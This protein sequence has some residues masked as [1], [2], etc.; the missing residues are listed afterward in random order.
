MGIFKNSLAF[1]LL[2]IS[3][4][5]LGLPLLVDSFILLHRAYV[6][7]VE[8]Q[9]K[10]LFRAAVRHELPI[11]LLQPISQQRLRIFE[12]ELAGKEGAP[13]KQMLEKQ[14][15]SSHAAFYL[16]KKGEKGMEIVAQSS[17]DPARD[18][19]VLDQMN[20]STS[21]S[22]FTRFAYD[23]SHKAFYFLSILMTG[24]EPATFLVAV[25]RITETV[26]ASLNEESFPFPTQ[27]ALLFD[28]VVVDAT[29][30]GLVNQTFKETT[31]ATFLEFDWRGQEQVGYL[32][33]LPHQELGV[34]AYASR[35]M[36]VILPLMEF[37][38]TYA[39]YSC[40]LIVGGLLS[41]LITWRLSKPMENLIEV[42]RGLEKGDL[43]CRYVNDPFGYEIND[44][45]AIFNRMIGALL[46]KRELAEEQRIRR[47]TYEKEL[48]I[49]QE[50]QRTLLLKD[51]PQ[52]PGVEL[53]AVCLPAK[54]VGGDFCD[55]FVKEDGT[56]VLTIADA[57]GKGIQA[58]FY[59]LLIRSMLR[60]Y[61]YT[62]H[63]PG[64][65]L[66]RTNALFVE[67]VNDSGMFVTTFMG[68]YDPKS[69]VLEYSS[70]GHNPPLICKKGG[71]TFFL[72]PEGIA[73]GIL[74]EIAKKTEKFQLEVGDLILLYTDGVTEAHSPGGGLF[75]EERLLRWLEKRGDFDLKELV[76]RLVREVKDFTD[77]LPQHDDITIIF[78]R[79]TE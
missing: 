34:L 64:E 5:L 19:A 68:I 4:I 25:H 44:L 8:V 57:S 10:E 2:L 79:V 16:L 60:S 72:K 12:K 66:A 62:F 24:K 28:G 56:L 43:S 54:E 37:V 75:S 40:I 38:D 31:P 29:D 36:V 51:K 52:V 74:P 71:E 32:R 22:F 70:C 27:F 47:V 61:A 42:M 30:P 11:A 55:T 45:G 53:L 50:A 78:M 76:D 3:L 35:R 77:G 1:R 15:T 46:E 18:A 49:G 7:S 48:L 9:K 6:H 41:F 63:E 21:A 33:M 58:C 59:S 69:H 13:L 39:I 73:L 67:D 26:R 17:A 23:S 14:A 65:V 20:G